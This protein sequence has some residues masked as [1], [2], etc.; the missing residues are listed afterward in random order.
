MSVF[1]MFSFFRCCR[2]TQLPFCHMAE[3]DFIY[4]MEQSH[5]YCLRWVVRF[6]YFLC[7]KACS[8]LFCRLY[9]CLSLPRPLPISSNHA[10]HTT[11]TDTIIL[12]TDKICR[13]FYVLIVCII[14]IIVVII[15]ILI[16]IIINIIVINII[17][18]INLLSSS[19]LSFF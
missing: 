5:E 17:I 19:T 12:S 11:A 1:N 9:V 3:K 2:S 16:V 15:I 4:R 6:V 7:I 10:L 8:A 13:Q 18:I 14:V